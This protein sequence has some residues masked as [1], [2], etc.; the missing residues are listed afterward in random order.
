MTGRERVMNTF[1]RQ[2]CDR[3]PLF[4]VV[5]SPDLY[6]SVL[7]V[8]NTWSDGDRAA[9][10]AKTLGLDAVMVPVSS[11]TG[12]MKQENEWIDPH[13]F[14]D[15]FGVGF[16][17][18]DTSWPLGF[19]V[20]E[21][22]LD[23]DFLEHIRKTVTILETDMKPIEDAL[24]VAHSGDAEEIAVFGGIRSAFSFLSI[25]GGLVALSMLIY[26]D[27]ELLHDLV[28]A[29]TEYWTEVGLKMIAKGVDALYVANDMGM[30]GSTIISPDHLRE[31]FLP[32]F[33]RQCRA[34]KSAGVRVILH[35]CGN[36]ESILPDLAESGVIDGLNNL[37]S[38]AGMDITSV[39]ERYGR[40]W[41]LIG[42]VDATNVMTSSDTTVIDHAVS[43]VIAAAADGGG[44]ILA[45]DHSFHQGIPEKNILHF[46]E[47]A[48]LQG[49]EYCETSRG[50]SI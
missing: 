26:E 19:A 23:R 37:Q 1:A 25:S 31:F 9:E 28:D 5:N 43:E 16:T 35:S 46:I 24:A 14:T 21:V 38:Q 42:N 11:Y 17:I 8:E 3:I 36:I 49:A 32:A 50:F 34:W 30:N 45:T 13:N 27:P 10:L 41:T 12:L 7:G 4:D 6:S 39:K 48:K 40:E 33:F 20:G 47:Q 18:T 22:K 15:R 44:L 2:D 29:A